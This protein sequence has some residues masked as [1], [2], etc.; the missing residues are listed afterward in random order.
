MPLK[1]TH[2]AGRDYRY[3]SIMTDNLKTRCPA[4]QSVDLDDFGEILH[5][6]P[7]MVAGVPINLGEQQYQLCKCNKCQLRFKSP[8]VE[9]RRL[10]ACYEASNSS[11]WNDRPDPHRRRFDEMLSLVRKFAPGTDI[12]D[13]G[14]FN[15]AMLEYF[16]VEFDRFGI[17]PS[18]DAAAVAR[19]RGVNV[20]GASLY[21]I[22]PVARFDAVL[23]IDVLEHIAEPV[24]FFEKVTSVLR[25]G[26]VFISLTG[27]ADSMSWKLQGARHWYC[28][29]PEHVT[30]FDRKSIGE[31]GRRAGL[32]EVWYKRVS[33]QRN[34]LWHWMN[35]LSKNLAFT[36]A[37]RLGG[38]RLPGIGRKL[39][40][41]APVWLSATDH[42]LHVGRKQSR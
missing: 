29:L 30:F 26:G 23:A 27:D 15:G 25:P 36:C 9:E 28:S 21:D 40:R 7:A 20:L 14:C 4:C 12:I 10:T 35:D 11:H 13:I 17:E 19:E 31:L 6:L 2:A 42:M 22:P 34:G 8:A 16:G 39:R 1:N 3:N 41:R 24:V 18:R 5:A 37:Y 32:D 33:H 38:E